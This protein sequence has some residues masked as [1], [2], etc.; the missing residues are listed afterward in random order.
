VT[1]SWLD[2]NALHDTFN[3]KKK[4]LMICDTNNFPKGADKIIIGNNKSGK[5]LGIIFYL[6]ARGYCKAR[7]IEADI[8]D[9][10]NW[11]I[12]EEEKIEVK[13]RNTDA[14]YGV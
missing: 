14:R 4:V 2:K 6:L 8:P 5:S 9:L 3:V 7:G 12:E 11:T 13:T 1:D 10:E